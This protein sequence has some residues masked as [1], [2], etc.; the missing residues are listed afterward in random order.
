MVKENNCTSLFFNPYMNK[1]FMVRM[2]RRSDARFVTTMSHSLQAGS[3]NDVHGLSDGYKEFNAN[4]II[5]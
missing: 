2:D 4:A 5:Y 3:K 1:E